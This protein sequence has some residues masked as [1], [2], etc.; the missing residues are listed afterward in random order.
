MIYTILFKRE[1]RSL[2]LLIAF[3]MALL[4]FRIVMTES[5]YFAFLVW[6]LILA[7]VPLF[8]TRV[9]LKRE[10]KN[11]FFWMFFA[12]CWLLFLPN[13]PYILTDFLHFRRET[14]MPSWFDL[15]M[16][17]AFS[18]GGLMFGFIS[19]D[20][21]RWH[22]SQRFTERFA[23]IVTG[24]CAIASGFGIYIG[25]YLRLN[26][27]DVFTDPISAFTLI[28]NQMFSLRAIGFSIGYGFFFLILYN[29]FKSFS[30]TQS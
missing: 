4:S 26:S 30:K 2:V 29:I 18:F 5:I 9:V 13:A 15:L 7:A 6:N 23:V 20:Q 3:S 16:L 21:M 12:L 25:R 27:W 22:L 8:L 14:N 10:F 11:R 28:T 19:M 17:A 1:S 24:I